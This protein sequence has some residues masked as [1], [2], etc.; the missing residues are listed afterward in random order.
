MAAHRFDL[1]GVCMRCGLDQ[2]ELDA[3]D[4]RHRGCRGRP[5][6]RMTSDDDPPPSATDPK[7][8]PE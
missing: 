5:V 1:N 8:D 6:R 4:V 7:P 3:F 2:D